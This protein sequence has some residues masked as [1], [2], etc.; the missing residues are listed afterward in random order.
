MALLGRTRQTVCAWARKG[1]IP[2]S[3]LPDGNYGFRRDAIE[4][5]LSERQ[6][7]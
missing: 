6:A 5:W 7:A 2:A 1:L 3:R 4:A